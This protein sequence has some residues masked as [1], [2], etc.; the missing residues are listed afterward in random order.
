ME[1]GIKA[2]GARFDVTEGGARS[3]PVGWGVCDGILAGAT[4]PG[5]TAPP[6]AAF[7]ERQRSEVAVQLGTPSAR[8]APGPH[9][10]THSEAPLPTVQLPSLPLDRVRPA[11]AGGRA[12]RV[13]LWAVLG[14]ASVLLITYHA[15]IT[16]VGEPPSVATLVL[17]NLAAAGCVGLLAFL[18]S[19]T[20]SRRLFN[21]VRALWTPLVVGGLGVVLEMGLVAVSGGPASVDMKT[22]VPEGFG[23]VT[24]VIG[25]ALIETAVALTLL[26]SLRALVLFKRTSGSVRNWRLMLAAM[27]AAALVLL[28]NSAIDPVNDNV[29]HVVLLILAVG[30]MV[31]NAFRLAWIVYL[32]FRQKMLTL[33]LSVGLIV[34]FGYLFQMRYVESGIS[35]GAGSE[36]GPD[37]TMDLTLAAVFSQP[38]SQFVMMAFAFGILYASTAV[39]SLLFHLPT[40]A[41]LQQKTGEMEALQ[42]LARLSGEVFDRDKLVDTIAG[43]PVEAGVAQAAWLALIDEESGSLAPRIT[44]AFGLTPMQIKALTDYE[45][46]ARD[47]LASKGPILLRQ[48]PADHRIR[49]RPGDGIGSL[50]V[51]PLL[52]HAEPIGAL[53]ATRAVAEGFE[54][55]DVDALAAFAG[56]AALA[57][58]NADLFAERLERERLQRELAI[59]REVQQRLLPQSLPQAPGIALSATS[60]PAAEVCGDYYDFVEIGDGCFGVIV[61]DVSGKGTS[62]AF[63]MAELKGIFQSVS[64]LTRS[65]SEFLVR[66]NEALAGSLGKNAFITAV[67]GVMD[68]TAGTFTL[69]RAGHCPVAHAHADGTVDLLRVGG[70]GLGLDRGPLFRRSLKEQQIALQPGDAFVL[71]S[72]GLVETRD[73]AGDEYGYDR[74]AAAVAKHR[75]L[76]PDALRDALLHD[77]YRFAG[78]DEWDDDLTLVIV[79]WE[80]LPARPP[81]RGD[82]LAAEVSGT[83]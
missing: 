7:P 60:I 82:A 45:T 41:A 71:Y 39:L 72:D 32:P 24:Q 6:G 57:L 8:Y 54:D 19:D 68:T 10:L 79:K 25:V 53:F 26:L 64:K 18:L 62:A 43:A 2:L 67:Y 77:L 11:L 76:G 14:L 58:N 42:A 38:L 51:L 27:A 66:A 36:F 20:F 22:G 49:A 75:D 55:D 80:G 46:L 74:L 40:A 28:G 65:P 21:P 5:A 12:R 3:Y 29:L 61:G 35:L 56:Q 23:D 34:A 63:Y 44:A 30:T 73:R 4:A 17:V 16:A 52:A 31:M 48:A 69:A 50:L 78:H 33:G 47:A 9:S 1:G 15:G 70:L 59:A 13:V 83:A 37:L 81:T